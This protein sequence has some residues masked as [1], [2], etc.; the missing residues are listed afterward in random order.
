[1]IRARNQR[2]RG[3]FFVRKVLG[4]LEV[5]GR[6]RTGTGLGGLAIKTQPTGGERQ[7]RIQ[8][9]GAPFPLNCAGHATSTSTSTATSTFTGA[10][11]GLS[12]VLIRHWR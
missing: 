4:L 7:L 6:V 2:T 12:Q 5:D 1:M 11:G 9:M 8:R 3:T 10:T